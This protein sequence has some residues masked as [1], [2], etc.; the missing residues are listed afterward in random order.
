MCFDLNLAFKKKKKK[1]LFHK[2]EKLF[3][4]LFPL[5]TRA[6]MVEAAILEVF[7]KPSC[8]ASRQTSV[9]GL[10]IWGTRKGECRAF[11]TQCRDGCLPCRVVKSRETRVAKRLR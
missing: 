11:V 2:S 4:G 5:K 1:K 3:P 7:C 6:E 9:R 10:L 8:A